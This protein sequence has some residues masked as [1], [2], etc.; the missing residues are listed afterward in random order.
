MTQ[1]ITF[2]G[3]KLA[4][5]FDETMF[6]KYKVL[7]PIAMELAGQSVAHSFF[8]FHTKKLKL[9]PKKSI[10][11]IAG[12]GSYLIRQWRRLSCCSQTSYCFDA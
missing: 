12:P 10:L 8:D 7:S 6:S 1:K 4:K 5:E 2:V 3:Q 9:N 11:A